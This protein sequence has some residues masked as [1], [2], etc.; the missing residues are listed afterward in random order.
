MIGLDWGSRFNRKVVVGGSWSGILDQR[1]SHLEEG[2]TLDLRRHS[3]SH[4]G[5]VVGARATNNRAAS[6]IEDKVRRD[7]TGK[8]KNSR[9]DATLIADRK[10]DIDKERRNTKSQRTKED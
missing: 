5:V 4:G 2:A 1:S 8:R 6:G 10:L 3:G 7:Q 9:S